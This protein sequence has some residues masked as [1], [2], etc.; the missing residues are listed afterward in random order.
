MAYKFQLGSAI[1]S[2][3]VVAE[4]S[5][6]FHSQISIGN[7]EMNETDLEK[8]DGI[9]NGTIAANKAIVVDGNLDA[10]GFRHF[11]GTGDVTAGGSF[12]IGSADLDET[13]MEKLD[14][15]TNGT[16]AAAKAVVVDNNKDISSFRNVTATRFIGEHSGSVSGAVLQGGM[17]NIGGGGIST[18]G[19]IEGQAGTF[20]TLSA[21][22]TL[23]VG[24]TV[25]LDGAIGATLVASADSIYFFDAT[26]NLMKKESAVNYAATLAGGNGIDASAGVLFLDLNELVATTVDVGA[27]SIAVIDANAGGGSRKES[28]AD[29]AALQ[30]GTGIDAASGVFSTSAAQ[31]GI[32]SLLA[33]DIKIGEDDQTKIDFETPDEIHFYAA[34]SEQVYVAN[35]IFGPESDSAVDLGSTGVRWANAYVDSLTTTANVIVGGDLTVNGTTTTVNSTTINISSSF[36][37]EGPADAHETILNAGTPVADSEL[38]LPQLPSGQ[39]HLAALAD[40][41]TAASS[42]VTAAELAILDGNTAASSFTIADGDQMII[43]DGGNGGTLVQAT[44]SS[45]KTYMTHEAVLK[46]VAGQTLIVG[47]NY[48]DDFGSDGE[49]AVTLPQ[50]SDMVVGQRIKVKAPSDCSAT[51]YLVINTQA[52]AQKID[53]VNSIKLESPHAA[54]ELVYVDLNHFK[55]F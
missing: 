41:P 35:G 37:F 18:Q 52:T 23:S 44:M 15:I 29:M 9:S 21:S 11:T 1:L 34:N 28:I 40:A 14:G 45:L 17:L 5:G 3:S 53:G 50:S 19:N 33:T 27:D 12:I 47:V 16:V 7:A 30:A 4:G 31:T 32:T 48:F 6:E 36:T 8:L 55:V 43:N 20:T 39:Y 49:D 2:G 24:G 54:V 10:S 51:R 25:R 13:D 46:K 38:F 26:D 22:S 42:A